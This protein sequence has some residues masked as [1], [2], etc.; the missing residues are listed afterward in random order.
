MPTNSGRSAATSPRKTTSETRNRSGK[1]SSSA[2][3]RSSSTCA[4][5]CSLI[6]S[7]PPSVTARH[8]LEPLD[9]RLGVRAVAQADRDVGG[10]PVARHELARPARRV[11][12]D[13]R[14]LRPARGG[15]DLAELRL[16]R[17]RP[18][19]GAE[20]HE[21][22]HVGGRPRRRWRR[23][24]PRAPGPPP[25][26]A[27]RSRRRT[28]AGRRPGRRSPPPRSRARRRRPGRG[29]GGDG[30]SGR[31]GRAWE[32]LRGV[33]SGYLVLRRKK[34]AVSSWRIAI[35]SAGAHQSPAQGSSPA[36]ALQ[37]ERGHDVEQHP[38]GEELPHVRGLGAGQRASPASRA[39]RS[40]RGR[41]PG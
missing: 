35:S 5:A 31:G 10:A 19:G 36:I 40:G 12:V 20:P 27:D 23:R 6:S 22:D 32:A 11:G 2:R 3:A 37:V 1:A 8:A 14:D 30:G 38:V 9:Q 17:R 33:V 18:G 29:G 13:A 7:G 39:R 34:G 4:P 24:S 21:R 28:A 41:G 25:R 26:P 16:P 15:H